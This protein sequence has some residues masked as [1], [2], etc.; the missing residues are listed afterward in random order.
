[1]QIL[2]LSY[3]DKIRK[4]NINPI[5]FNNTTLLVGV[6]GVGK[7]QIIRAILALKSIAAGDS[8]N[9][10]NWSIEFKSSDGDTYLWSGE[11]ETLIGLYEKISKNEVDDPVKKKPKIIN[12]KVLLNGE[13]IIK[14]D[15]TEILF[16]G[17]PTIKLSRFESVISLLREEEKI[18]PAYRGFRKIILSSNSGSIEDNM[19]MPGV[20]YI[21]ELE[22]QYNDIESIK[23]L[24]EHF[25]IK[26]YLAS[27]YYPEI[28]EYI[29]DRFIE[30]FPQVIDMKVSV[31]ETDKQY[32]NIYENDLM[33]QIKEKYVDDWIIEKNISSGMFRTLKHLSEIVLSAKG[34]VILIDEFENS[35]GVNC[36]DELTE[37][38]FSNP[39]NNI[40]FII[41]SH[42][43]YIINN[44][45][46][47]FWKIVTRQAGEINTY[48]AKQLNLG[49]SKHEA[50]LQLINNQEFFKGISS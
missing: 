29:R 21:K 49:T 5:E 18:I 42:H 10:V 36:I 45:N 12:E 26:L 33:I 30:I 44:I 17:T 1:M 34:T 4:I 9:A 13:E 35:L 20:Q 3:Q 11:F 46:L 7:T 8:V 41:T 22:Y 15:G 47:S 16:L 14:R 39:E 40:Q 48:N 25:K 32:Y 31:F 27:V 24:D 28:F 23:E 6:S 43:P 38:L 2:K 19:Y 37:D 50:F